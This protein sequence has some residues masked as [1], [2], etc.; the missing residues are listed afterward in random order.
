MNPPRIFFAAALTGT[1]LFSAAAHAQ[2]QS[3]DTVFYSLAAPPSDFE[4][5]CFGPCACPILLRSPLTGTFRL[6]PSGTDPLYTHYA[7]LDV[8]W[9][10][11]DPTHAVTITGSGSYRRGGEFG[12][13][14]QLT[15][16]LSFDGGPTQHFDSGLRT[17]GAPFPEIDT[18]VSLHGVFC[19]DSLLKVDA[20]PFSGVLGV[21]SLVSLPWLVAAPNPFAS[22][23]ELDF[24]LSAPGSVNL[25]VYDVNGRHVR[26]L[27]SGEWFGAGAQRLVW[28][29]DLDG[30][31]PARAGVYLVRLALPSG[32]LTRRIVK[33]R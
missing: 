32:S 23:A 17:P 31:F 18:Q 29:G 28:D 19:F 15:L 3:P 5:G 12:L 25:D 6:T 30:G 13:M 2:N 11:P 20:K 10:V 24:A 8:R 26:A 9:K 22:S 16:D 21:G 33:I 4:Y 1:L 14:E 7:V 27:V